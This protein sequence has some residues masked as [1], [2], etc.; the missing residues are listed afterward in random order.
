MAEGPVC[1]MHLHAP[2]AGTDATAALTTLALL[3][4]LLPCL[5]ASDSCPPASPTSAG[6]SACVPASLPFL[7]CRTNTIG[8]VARIRNALAFA[9]HR[10][11][12]ERGFL[13]VHT[14]IVTASDCEGAG[15]MFQVGGCGWVAVGGWMGVLVSYWLVLQRSATAAQRNGAQSSDLAGATAMRSTATQRC[16]NAQQLQPARQ[17]SL[18]SRLP[19]SPPAQV[20][21]L[22]NKVDEEPEVPPATPEQLAA[23][24]EQVGERVGS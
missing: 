9:T 16:M 4:R 2:A 6:F 20:T 5:P 17:P 15:E 7:P 10:F 1:G 11:F 13:Y 3:A 14:P 8:A 12:Q 23:L 19:P 18:S 22:L 21:T 24:R